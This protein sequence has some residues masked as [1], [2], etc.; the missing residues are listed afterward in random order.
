M[1]V[2]LSAD[3][4]H[5]LL[6][7]TGHLGLEEYECAY[8]ANPDM[9]ILLTRHAY[10]AN[11]MSRLCWVALVNFNF[12]LISTPYICGSVKTVEI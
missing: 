12:I 2:L 4:M 7:P 11:P 5:I 1:Q 6:T 3:N 9:H 10:F 8:F